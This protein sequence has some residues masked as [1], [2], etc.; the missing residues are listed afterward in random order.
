ME[1]A[2]SGEWVLL[3]NSRSPETELLRLTVGE[4]KAFVLGLNGGEFVSIETGSSS[5]PGAMG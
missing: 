4:W 3:R 5:T 1:V 2:R